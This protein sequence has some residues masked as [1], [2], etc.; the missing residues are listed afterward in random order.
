MNRY[1]ILGN[2]FDLAHNLPTSYKDFLFVCAEYIELN[3]TIRVKNENIDKVKNG[4]IRKYKDDSNFKRLV[5]NNFWLKNFFNK[6]E[7]IGDNWID[8]EIEIKNQCESLAKN[9]NHTFIDLGSN[10]VSLNDLKESLRE[11]IY[12][13]NRYLVIVNKIEIDE[14]YL[15]YGKVKKLYG[16]SFD[17]EGL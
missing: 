2:G 6:L 4:F 16:E 14:C 1:L 13:L 3:H 9:I 10:K 17:G 7:N 11:L 5:K 15:D 8:F 12:I